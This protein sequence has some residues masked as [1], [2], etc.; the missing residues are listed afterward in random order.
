MIKEL[1]PEQEAQLDVYAERYQKLGLRTE[2]MDTDSDET[3]EA[4]DAFYKLLGYP[5]PPIVLEPSPRAA[6]ETV[7]KNTGQHPKSDIV[8]PG[9]LCNVDAGFLGW[10][11]FFSEVLGIKFDDGYQHLRK[12]INLHF[13]WTLD[14]LCV[15]CDFPE[16]IVLQDGVLHCEDGPVIRYSDGTSIWIID[17]VVVDEQIVM[18]PET[19]TIE[20]INGDTNADRRAIRQDRFGWHWYLPAMGITDPVDQRDN[21]VEGTYEALFDAKDHMRF[22]YTCVTGRI[23]SS[24]LPR[25]V[26]T[27]EQAQKWLAGNRKRNVLART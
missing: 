24:A 15:L 14:E 10:C 4:V 25:D 7:C 1:T 17:N 2:P 22:I 18:R 9:Y 5:T 23:M 6:W 12:L 16:R 26:R 21:L 20:Q 13:T 8:W 11:A 27:C 19:Q 3:K